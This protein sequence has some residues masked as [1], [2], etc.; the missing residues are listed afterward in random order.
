MAPSELSWTE[1]AASNPQRVVTNRHSELKQRSQ[2]EFGHSK[3][4]EGAAD[5]IEF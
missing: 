2:F 1:L 3:Y 4:M 5:S